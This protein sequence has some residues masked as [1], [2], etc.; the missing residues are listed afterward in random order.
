MGRP[1]GWWNLAFGHICYMHAGGVKAFIAPPV[2]MHRQAERYDEAEPL[3]REALDNREGMLFEISGFS[4]ECGSPWQVLSGLRAQLG[5]KHPDSLTGGS[6]AAFRVVNFL[7][8]SGQTGRS[9]PRLAESVRQEV[10][11][12]STAAL[13]NACRSK[14]FGRASLC[15]GRV[16]QGSLVKGWRAATCSETSAPTIISGCGALPGS[17]DWSQGAVR[18]SEGRPWQ[19]YSSEISSTRR[20]VRRLVGVVS[21]W[22]AS[23]AYFHRPPFVSIS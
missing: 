12:L 6:T 1:G 10:N 23:R 5:D 13:G 2:F 20:P 22:C 14:Q 21:A 17:S 11:L 15:E 3:F 19:L 9:L 7:G 16:C 18:S 4:S 8:W